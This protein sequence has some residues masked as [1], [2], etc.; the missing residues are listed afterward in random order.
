MKYS[1]FLKQ[2]SKVLN[3]NLKTIHTCFI[4]SNI[5][6]NKILNQSVIR[7]IKQK[8]DNYLMYNAIEKF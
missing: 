1:D 4:E 6:I 5:D 8:F 7:I 3:I 2:L